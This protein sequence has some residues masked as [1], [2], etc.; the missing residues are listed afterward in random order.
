MTEATLRKSFVVAVDGPAASGKG[1]ISRR[2]AARFD[3][4]Y[5]DTGVLYRAVAS[6]AM[7]RGRD[8]RD[9]EAMGAVAEDLAQSDLH[10][11]DLRSGEVGAAASIVAAHPPVRAA[12][13]SF[14]RFFAAQPAG[15]R[16]GAVLDGRDIGTVVCPDADVK[17]FVTASL[18]ARAQR[19]FKDLDTRGETMDLAAVRA[20]L[21][22]RDARDR[23]R[24][25]A[26]LLQAPDARLLDTTDLD[27]EQAV[28][29]AADA[30]SIAW[31]AFRASQ[32]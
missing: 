31:R 4:A 3:F 1:T 17:L 26:P 27:I 2:V 6:V 13:L 18:E 14:Q 20:D 30:I 15:G 28:A 12:L 22:E 29:A 21:A 8:L 7:E 25:T 32:A 24:S 16:L 10:R 19:R 5:L 11:Q 9:G 23:A